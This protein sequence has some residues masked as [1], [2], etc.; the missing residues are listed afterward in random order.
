V[1]TKAILPHVSGDVVHSQ[2]MEPYAEE[3]IG[4]QEAE[5]SSATI[6]EPIKDIIYENRSLLIDISQTK[7]VPTQV[8]KPCAMILE[9]AQK[10]RESPHKV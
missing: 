6:V 10:S 4:R 5:E 7:K 9:F 1:E 8:H 3:V 2:E